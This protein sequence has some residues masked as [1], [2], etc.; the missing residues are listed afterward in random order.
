MKKI[1]LGAAA[2][3]ATLIAGSAMAQPY[4][5]SS[6]RGGYDANRYAYSGSAYAYGGNAYNNGYSNSRAYRDSDGDG[7]SDRAE[8]GRD[9]D[10]DGRPDQW[11]RYDNRRDRYVRH[12]HHD[13]R[14]HYGRNDRDWRYDR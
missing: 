7:I 3:V 5:Y 14:D 2:A 4:G 1:I 11:D 6:G 10:R 13:R 9:R 12:D 8:W